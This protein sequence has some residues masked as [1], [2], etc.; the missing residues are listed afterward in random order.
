LAQAMNASAMVSGIAWVGVRNLQ[1]RDPVLVS[2]MMFDYTDSKRKECS[3]PMA[4]S[5][6][7]MDDEDGV[8]APV[9]APAP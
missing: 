8:F 2:V 3:R 6:V 9:A 1:T 5:G 4:L 7:R